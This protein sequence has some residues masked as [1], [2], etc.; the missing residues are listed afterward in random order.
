MKVHGFYISMQC[1]IN[2]LGR[3]PCSLSLWSI[4][5]QSET[6]SIHF[7]GSDA[8]HSSLMI[9]PLIVLYTHC[10][11]IK[12]VCSLQVTDSDVAAFR[13]IVGNNMITDPADVEPYNIDWMRHY[14]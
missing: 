4:V 7:P 3:C 10:M 9:H 6:Q 8:S 14:Q 5:P 11:I 2:R 12:Q 1:I 13:S